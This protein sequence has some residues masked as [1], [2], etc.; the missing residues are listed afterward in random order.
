MPRGR[1]EKRR[2]LVWM[3]MFRKLDRKARDRMY[4]RLKKKGKK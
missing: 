2:K 4:I 1:E 3:R